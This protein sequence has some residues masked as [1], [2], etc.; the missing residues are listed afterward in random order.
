MKFF[1]KKF[2]YILIKLI[3]SAKPKQGRASRYSDDD[4]QIFELYGSE[5]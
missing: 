3:A 2:G 5:N 4:M 1:F